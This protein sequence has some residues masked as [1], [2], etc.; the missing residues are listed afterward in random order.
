[1]TN[2]RRRIGTVFSPDD[3]H[4]VALNMWRKT[5][6]I[7]RKFVNQVGSL[8]KITV[9][10]SFVLVINEPILNLECS[11]IDRLCGLVVRVSGYRY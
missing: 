2:T 10:S 5:L 6:N 7:L 1:M 9:L 3:G 8:Y 4:I 11:S